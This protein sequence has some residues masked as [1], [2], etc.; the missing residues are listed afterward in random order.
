MHARLKCSKQS[1]TRRKWM[2]NCAWRLSS[3]ST[4]SRSSPISTSTST[5]T[6]RSRRISRTSRK[7]S[8]ARSL[9][10]LC[11]SRGS[12]E[13]RMA[14]RRRLSQVLK[15]SCRGSKGLSAPIRKSFILLRMFS[16]RKERPNSSIFGSILRVS[17]IQSK[18]WCWTHCMILPKTAFATGSSRCFIRTLTNSCSLKI[19]PPP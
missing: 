2:G 10:G 3:A 13:G 16:C 7:C 9:V 11:S 5:R 15:T 14:S 19:S 17:R 1:K 18:R 12:R 8:V 6:L 4:A